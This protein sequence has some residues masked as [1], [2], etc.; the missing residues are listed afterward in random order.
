MRRL[1]ALVVILL[2]IAGGAWF[3]AGRAAGPTLAIAQPTKLVGQTGD[4]TVTIESPTAL[5]VLD[6]AIEQDGQRIPVFSLPGD[7]TSK[8][9]QEGDGKLRLTRAIG[10]RALPQLK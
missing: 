3:A 7:N 1:L 9:T 6:V 5:K 8:L 10:K 4:L 2:V